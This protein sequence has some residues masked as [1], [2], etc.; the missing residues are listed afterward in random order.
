MLQRNVQP[1]PGAPGVLHVNASFRNDA[2]WPQPWPTVLLTL[3]DID[4][5]QVGLRAFKPGEYLRQGPAT[6]R[7]GKAQRFSWT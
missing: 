1:K 6:S 7:P 5:R 4:G 3:S 2:R